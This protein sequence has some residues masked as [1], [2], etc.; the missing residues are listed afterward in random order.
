MIKIGFDLGGILSKYPDIF[1]PIISALTNTQ[2]DIS[3]CCVSD[4]HPKEKIEE[5]LRLNSFPFT[6]DM[7]YSADYKTHGELCKSVV[8]EEQKID[9]LIDDHMGYLCTQGKPLVRL[10]M[11]PDPT[12]PY[13]DDSWKTDGSEGDFGRRRNPPGSKRPPEDRGSGKL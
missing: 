4:M 6:K 8:C 9:I 11:M 1:R 7:V 2:E 3:V 12:L 13:Y 5:W 10:F